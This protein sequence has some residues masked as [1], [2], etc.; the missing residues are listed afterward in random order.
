MQP[1]ELYIANVPFDEHIGSKV[2]PALVLV[3]KQKYVTVFKI[4]SQ[5]ENKSNKIKKLYYP[6]KLWQEAGLKKQSYVDI[7]KNYE[8]TR[9]AVFS[10]RPIG[11]LS[12]IDIIGLS[13]FI[14]EQVI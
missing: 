5:Y 11:K 2:R 7:H 13:K 10:R 9:E 3:V 12:S 1:M 4:T 8:I 6:I 14:K